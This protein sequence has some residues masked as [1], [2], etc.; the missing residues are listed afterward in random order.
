MYSPFN[1]NFYQSHS[2]KIIKFRKTQT[3]ASSV[4]LRVVDVVWTLSVL[5][6]AIVVESSEA[7]RV[8]AEF[9]V[10]GAKQRRL[11]RRKSH[12]YSTPRGDCAFVRFS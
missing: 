5:H 12:R 4:A 9:I 10:S 2:S 6:D 8:G 11:Y 3:E 7:S 1:S